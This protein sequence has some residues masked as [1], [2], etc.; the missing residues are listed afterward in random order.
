MNRIS[1][2]FPPLQT[3]CTSAEDPRNFWPF[4]R[5]W[6]RYNITVGQVNTAIHVVYWLTQMLWLRKV[7]ITNITLQFSHS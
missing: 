7:Q 4:C 6:S 5:S 2:F 3:R 1:Q